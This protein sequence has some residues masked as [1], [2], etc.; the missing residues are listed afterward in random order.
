MR[1]AS[2]V[3]AMVAFFQLTSTA[4]PGLEALRARA[5]EAATTAREADAELARSLADRDR[6]ERTLREL[7]AAGTGFFAARRIRQQSA[8]VRAAVERSL[9]DAEAARAA[10]ERLDRENAALRDGLFVAA[11]IATGAGDEAARAGRAS[12]AQAHYRGAAALLAE[13]ARVTTRR[14]DADPFAGLAIAIPLTGLENGREL[15]AISAAYRRAAEE[16]ATRAAAIEARLAA[17][18]AA[19]SAWDRLSRFRGVL[20]RAGGSAADPRPERDRLAAEAARG[21]SVEAALRGRIDDIESRRIG[22]REA[23]P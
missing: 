16:A 5:S 9:E 20:E 23:A 8:A 2:L 21:R 15:S 18:E 12:D 19:V 14:D 22:A 4:D 1:A 11:S 6:E 3:L 17:T 7:E 13:A 10:S